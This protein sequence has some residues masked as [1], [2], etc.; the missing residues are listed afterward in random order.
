MC[1][2]ARLQTSWEQTVDPSL[3]V[4]LR[5]RDSAPGG[6]DHGH[7]LQFSDFMLC[8]GR[9]PVLVARGFSV[10]RRGRD[11]EKVGFLHACE[12]WLVT[13]AQGTYVWQKDL[14]EAGDLLV[15][16]FQSWVAR[17][18]SCLDFLTLHTEDCY[19]SRHASSSS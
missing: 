7:V 6:R 17:R 3:P 12:P 1:T 10:G 11:C 16:H 4:T 9:A 2:A 18:G 15:E 19:R 8:E 13:W 5:S 14:P